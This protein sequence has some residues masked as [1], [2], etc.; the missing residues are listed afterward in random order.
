MKKI[1]QLPAGHALTGTEMV[2]LV[3]D[4][5]TR[6]VP[7]GYFGGGSSAPEI[8]FP[9]HSSLTVADVGKLVMNAGGLARVAQKAPSL[10]GQAGKW[11]LSVQT[12]KAPQQAEFSFRFLQGQSIVDGHTFSL[13]GITFTFRN[14]PT[15]P[16]DIQIGSTDAETGMLLTEKLAGTDDKA[17]LLVK[18]E[19]LEG[20]TIH[21]LRAGSS[22][23]GTL[24]DYPNFT[25]GTGAFTLISQT[26]NGK[27]NDLDF[28]NQFVLSYG[29]NDNDN[30]YSGNIT[31]GQILHMVTATQG[32]LIGTYRWPA[33]VAEML[34]N[35]RLF[36]SAEPTFGFIFSV[37]PGIR[38]EINELTIP[39]GSN[40]A[41]YLEISPSTPVP[42]SLNT[43]EESQGSQTGF[44]IHPVLG[45]LKGL[46]GSGLARLDSGRLFK[47]RLA[48]D[49]EPVVFDPEIPVKM[50]HRM[51]IAT[52]NGEVTAESNES[53]EETLFT[54][55][56]F[57]AMEE[58]APGNEL[59]V[60]WIKM[61]GH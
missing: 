32:T 14:S 2:P 18:S 6:Q 42:V 27:N 25:S 29:K 12:P 4:G 13:F 7:A 16:Y 55:G 43:L 51:L 22:Y 8:T 35:L 61:I 46:D 23:P 60:E 19:D 3:Q 52:D 57:L 15:Q 48:D 24:G 45:V 28:I 26:I 21:T 59:L 39:Q 37:T 58:A 53:D 40:G 10:P 36:L 11:T 44:V 5:Q 56:V 9:A 1:S 49:S 31:L 20:E 38:L 34:E 50:E 17:F 54:N 41:A 33:T 47:V 30:H